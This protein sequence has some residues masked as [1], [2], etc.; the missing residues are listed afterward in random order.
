M[1]VE[2]A[3]GRTGADAQGAIDAQAAI[4]KEEA[5]ARVQQSKMIAAAEGENPTQQL[6]E[7]ARDLEKLRVTTEA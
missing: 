1:E 6:I 4:R 2:V 3:E 7:E 5:S